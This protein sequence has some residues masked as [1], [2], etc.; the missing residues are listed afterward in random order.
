M[1]PVGF[2]ASQIK[3]AEKKKQIEMAWNMS[4]VASIMLC[5]ST[6]LFKV[7]SAVCAGKPRCRP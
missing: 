4:S 2:G 5:R 7:D 3:S 6:K 1:G